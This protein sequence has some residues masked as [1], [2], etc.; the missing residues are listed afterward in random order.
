MDRYKPHV[1]TNHVRNVK[2]ADKDLDRI[3]ETCEKEPV[4]YGNVILSD[5]A[6][7]ALKLNPNYMLYDKIDEKKVEVEIEKGMTKARYSMMNDDKDDHE[8]NDVESKTEVFNLDEKTVN[9]AN[10]RATQLPTVQRLYPPQ[11]STLEKFKDSACT[12]L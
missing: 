2:Y 1:E 5:S 9:F 6:R 8:Q 12:L 4:I 3:E 11:P 7:E 10:M